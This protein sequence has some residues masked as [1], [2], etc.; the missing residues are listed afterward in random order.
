MIGI[1]KITS[2]SGKNYIGQ[3]IDWD[4]RQKMYK[5][6]NCKNQRK[7]YNSIQKYGWDKHDKKLIEECDIKNL[8][9]RERYWQEYYDVLNK[10]LNCK[11]TQTNDK[12]G[13]TSKETKNLISLGM[14]GKN[15]WSTGGYHKKSVLQ[16]SLN[17]DFIKN[18]TSVKEARK[19]YNVDIASCCR[20]ESKTSA[21]FL[22]FYEKNFNND[23]LIEKIKKVF[24]HG[25]KK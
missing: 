12:S 6:L 4:Q 23:L 10:G 15:T 8:N 19:I 2:P 22:W 11:L 17:G 5:S 13:S 24:S 16:Y 7:L 18:Y 9:I 3:T 20:G 21:G 1:Y 14:L 25:N